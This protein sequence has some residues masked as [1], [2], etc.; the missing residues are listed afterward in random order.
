MQKLINKP[1][2]VLLFVFFCLSASSCEAA[3]SSEMSETSETPTVPD[4][5]QT[6]GTETIGIFLNLIIQT[7]DGTIYESADDGETWFSDGE[8]V[9]KPALSAFFIGGL[10][11]PFSEGCKLYVCNDTETY[12][13]YGAEYQLFRE[14]GEEWVPVA[15]SGNSAPSKAQP[16]QKAADPTDYS[17]LFF[18]Q[19]LYTLPKRTRWRFNIPTEIYEPITGKYRYVKEFWEEGES[20]DDELLYTVILEFPLISEEQA[21]S[22]EPEKSTEENQP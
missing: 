8:S 9:E 5:A 4:E 13:H 6:D 20:Q 19:E 18:T 22:A 2:S 21:K 7:P 16:K 3:P 11:V 10:P 12:L 14:S 17:T 15:L 1:L